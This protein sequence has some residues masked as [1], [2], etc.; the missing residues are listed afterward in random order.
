MKNLILILTS[1]ILIS[2]NEKNANKS[3]SIIDREYQNY[4]QITSI[5][6]YTK[7]SDTVVYGKSIEPKHSILHLKK[8]DNHLIIFN[9]L[10]I[11]KNQERKYKILD[12]LSLS[13]ISETDYL[14]IGY[15]NLDKEMSENLIALITKSDSLYLKKVNQVWLANV[16]TEKIEKLNKLEGI[17]CLNEFYVD[18]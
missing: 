11:D 7:I 8:G 16:K 5:S 2:C 9:K 10:E 6:D 17:K 1:L 3:E 12:T 13:K 4:N 15:C 14:S 18:K